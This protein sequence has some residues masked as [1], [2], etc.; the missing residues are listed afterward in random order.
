MLQLLAQKTGLLVDV[1]TIGLGLLVVLFG[2][3]YGAG[4]RSHVQRIL[5][6]LSTASLSAD[7]RAG[8]LADD[9]PHSGAAALT[10]G[11]SAR[12]RHA[13]QA[14][15]REQRCLYCRGD[16]VDRL[17][18]DRRAGDSGTM[19]EAVPLAQD[20]RTGTAV[21]LEL[22]KTAGIGKLFKSRHT[23]GIGLAYPLF[24]GAAAKATLRSR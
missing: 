11:V 5:I 20:C 3:R 15:Q 7:F 1:L 2:R 9:R 6:G 23:K 22:P 8:H 4:W 12:G 13:G 10:G 19:A 18:V 17:P 24:L 16:L 21:S 14:L